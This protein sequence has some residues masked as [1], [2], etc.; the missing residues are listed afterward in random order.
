MEAQVRIG[1]NRR[2]ILVYYDLIESPVP[3]E[4]LGV[5][6]RLTVYPT[7]GIIEWPD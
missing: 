5:S 3:L 7:T 6:D 1:A 2:F 4:F